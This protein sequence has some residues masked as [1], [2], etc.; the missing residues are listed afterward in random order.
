MVFRRWFSMKKTVRNDLISTMKTAVVSMILGAL[1]ASAVH[2]TARMETPLQKLV[3]LGLLMGFSISISLAVLERWVFRKKKSIPL[4]VRILVQ[5][6]L[7][8][9][10]IVGIYLLLSSLL[11][12]IDNIWKDGLILQT[13]SF[14]LAITFLLIFLENINRLLG[15]KLILRLLT[16]VYH[17]PV[18]EERFVMFLDIAGSTAIAESIRYDGHIPD[19]R[20]GLHYGPLIVGE[21]GNVRQ[22]IAFLGDVMH[23]ASRIQTSCRELKTRFLVSMNVLE[24]FSDLPRGIRS[25]SHGTISLRGKEQKLELFSLDNG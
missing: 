2:F 12:D 14:S 4:L 25:K 11:L 17:K 8:S 23:T 9:L 10:V 15:Q 24:K 20:A 5:P 21:M 13:L 6:V 7:Y 19:F 3:I 16:G 18:V 22:E 1:F